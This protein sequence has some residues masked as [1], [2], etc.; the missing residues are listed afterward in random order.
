MKNLNL[1]VNNNLKEYYLLIW[2][3]L[4]REFLGWTE[5]ETL[6]WAEKTG[7]LAFL[8]DPDDMIYH[9]IPQYWAIQAL[10]PNTLKNKLPALELADLKSRML[11]A[12]LTENKFFPSEDTDWEPYRQKIEQILGEYNENLPKKR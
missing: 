2:K 3:N 6:D 4:F 10:V 1:Q 8:A 9:Q 7:K 11:T 12:L 5:K